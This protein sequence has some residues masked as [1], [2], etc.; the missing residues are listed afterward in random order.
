MR[1]R[2]IQHDNE[3]PADAQQT[4]ART[5]RATPL[6]A[7]ARR[8]TPDTSCAVSAELWIG[9]HL[10]EP[11]SIRGDEPLPV[12][13][14]LE[15]LAVRAQRFTPR[16][17]LVPPD[18]LLLEVKGSLHLF[19]GV[20]GLRHALANEFAGL[21]VQPVL[22]LAPTPLAALAAARAG[23]PFVAMSMAQLVGQLTPLPLTTLRWPQPTLERLGRMG[24]RTIGQALR[25][26][27]AAFARRFG[28]EQL[29][30][31]D[32]LTGR[33]PDLPRRFHARERFRRRRELT[34]ELEN[35][36]L[37]R[38]SLE[39]LWADLGKFLEARQCGVMELECLLRH[40]HAPPTRCVRQERSARTRCAC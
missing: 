28:T 24:V 35:H 15:R 30:T 10:H 12:S 26:P 16:V 9:V 34:Y 37:I 5:Q 7:V 40:R 33:D 11:G 39:P 4:H 8:Q 21:R 14:E 1:S 22:A 25:L 36:E 2:G 17:S 20:D 23:K 32:R 3:R 38:A 27:R 31:L 29:A 18:G 19:N 13:Q 6:H